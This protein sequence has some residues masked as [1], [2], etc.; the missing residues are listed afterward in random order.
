[1]SLKNSCPSGIEGSTPSS[2]TIQNYE[3]IAQL[4]EHPPFKRVVVDSNST[5]LTIFN[6]KKG[7]ANMVKAFCQDLLNLQK[8]GITIVFE[9]K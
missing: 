3:T 7:E 1:M 5:G 6:L 9:E 4:V 2:S 8:Q